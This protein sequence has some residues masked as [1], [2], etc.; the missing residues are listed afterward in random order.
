MFVIEDAEQLLTGASRR[1]F[2]RAMALGGTAVLLPGV[3]AACDDDDDPSAPGVSSATLDLSGDRGILNYL[4]A[5]EQVQASF[6]VRVVQESSAA[7]FNAIQRRLIA[8]IR[9][10][11]F[12]HREA[13]RAMLGGYRL[14]EL[15][16]DGRY[17]G[18]NFRDPASIFATAQRLEDLGVS[19][20]ASAGRYV[21]DAA[22]LL[23]IA[24]I[25]SVEAR[26]SAVI[27]DF[28]DA[29]GANTGK[30][31][32][33]DDIVDENGLDAKG[34]PDTPVTVVAAL[35]PFID[36]TVSILNPPA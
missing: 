33:G 27:R 11:E 17:Q 14:P 20:Y 16:L 22:S 4:F 36:A 23:L 12:I 29:F 25:A 24:K 18:T 9:N 7:G 15:K 28:L 1:K 32:A 26:H 34:Q 35:D 21:T 6:Y 13:L 31:F 5:V 30:L 2:L 3:F 19:A 8:D 10:H